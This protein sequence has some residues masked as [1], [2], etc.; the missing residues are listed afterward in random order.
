MV[1][2]PEEPVLLLAHPDRYLVEEARRR[3][4]I[5]VDPLPGVFTIE[6][7]LAGKEIIWGEDN[8]F[9]TFHVEKG[10]VDSA[11]SRRRSDR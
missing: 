2:H 6:D 10:D 11:F 9:K 7:S 3:V 5:E 1:Q 4:R 8:I